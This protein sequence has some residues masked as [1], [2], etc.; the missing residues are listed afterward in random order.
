MFPLVL[1]V[2]THALKRAPYSHQAYCSYVPRQRWNELS[3]HPSWKK[4]IRLQILAQLLVKTLPEP[5]EAQS[6]S[7]ASGV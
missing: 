6:V 2:V 5:S 3:H 1:T 4:K 7:A